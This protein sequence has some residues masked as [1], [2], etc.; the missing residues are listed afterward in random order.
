MKT[1]LI[2]L[3]PILLLVSACSGTSATPLPTPA[4]PAW[5]NDL[6]T[7]FENAPVGNPPKSIWQYQYN[8]STVYYVPPQCCD[9]YSQLYDASG[10]V[11]CAPDGGFTGKGDGKCPDFFQAKGSGVLIWMDTRK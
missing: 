1:T 2:L 5:V 10:T 6:I 11:L 3:I 7:R 9:Q 8:G 4:N